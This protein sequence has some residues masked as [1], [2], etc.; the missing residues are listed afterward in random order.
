[1]TVHVV[2][3]VLAAAAV[4]ASPPYA[5]LSIAIGE[6]RGHPAAAGLRTAGPRDDVRRRRERR[7]GVAVH[8]VRDAPKVG[9]VTDAVGVTRVAVMEVSV[10]LA[11]VATGSLPSVPR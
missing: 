4:A 5:P 10:A 6:R 9:V 11:N 1:M 7:R 3:V 2:V 8:P